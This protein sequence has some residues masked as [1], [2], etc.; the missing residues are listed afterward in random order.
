MSAFS[1]L[2]LGYDWEVWVLKQDMLCADDKMD[3]TAERVNSELPHPIEAHR[4]WHFI[5]MGPGIAHEWA[6]LVERTQRYIGWV[7]A[8][9][10][11]ENLFFF[12]CGAI[13]TDRGTAGL[14]I[15]VGTIADAQAEI[16]IYNALI[17][18]IPALLALMVNSPI[19]CWQRGKWKA[20]R[21]AGYNFGSGGI[22]VIAEPH[23]A[24]ATWFGDVC[25][26]RG[27][28]PTIEVRLADCASSPR[29]LC[30]YALVVAGL[31]EHVASHL[32]SHPTTYPQEDYEEFLANRWRATKYGL[33]ATLTIG[34]REVAAADAVRE[35]IEKASAGMRKLSASEEDLVVIPKMLAKRITQ[36][37]MQ[38]AYMEK[39]P[40]P[41]A[42]TRAY[43][44]VLKDLSAFER[45]LE[46]AP[47]LPLL[48]PGDFDEA[49]IERIGRDT[50][51]A[52]LMSDPFVPPVI[53]EKKL[54][55]LEEQGRIVMTVTPEEGILCTRAREVGRGAE[56]KE[57]PGV[58]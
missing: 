52:T 43:V 18:Y 50:P 40:D 1:P 2:T 16:R 17:G 23:L 5:E 19:A 37:D 21:M 29:L 47:E 35:I 51:P 54:K 45:Y 31:L 41:V 42:F 25:Y 7:Q 10:A 20:Y 57:A 39:H 53:L 34:G 22:G 26:R 38:L 4:E 55:R 33:Q 15:H 49:I 28:K 44:D 13:A 14:H 3:K 27:S 6:E 36:A 12:P 32:D 30:E 58:V 48:A 8:E 46:I 24:N 56:R 11:K 9:M